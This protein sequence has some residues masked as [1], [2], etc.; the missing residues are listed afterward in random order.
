MELIYSDQDS[1]FDPAKFYANPRYFRTV[2]A[3]ATTVVVV[4][5]WPA[6]V[7]A[8]EA[9][10]IPVSSD[11]ATPAIAPDLQALSAQETAEGSFVLSP[12]ADHEAPAAK[13]PK[14]KKAKPNASD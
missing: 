5:D 14:G 6:V 10:G 3:R 7:L 12:E 11:K 2:N 9:I 13:V 8:Y 1:G 4:G